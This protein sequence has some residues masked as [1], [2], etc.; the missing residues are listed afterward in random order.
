MLGQTLQT[1]Y[2]DIQ[3]DAGTTS[4]VRFPDGFC[5]TACP[6]PGS[7]RDCPG[8]SVCASSGGTALCAPLCD[9]DTECREGYVCGASDGANGERAC[10]V[11][12]R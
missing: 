7:S 4:D 2:L 12:L 9:G 6:Q 10:I 1:C 3:T 5:S 8:G 11:D